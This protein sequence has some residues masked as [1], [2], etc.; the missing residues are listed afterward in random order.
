M[1]ILI[2][3]SSLIA[4]ILAQSPYCKLCLNSS[5]VSNHI[6]CLNP[7]GAWSSACPVTKS[8]V[9]LDAALILKEHNNWRNELANGRI[10]GFKPATNMMKLVSKSLIIE[11]KTSSTAR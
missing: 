8:L 6:I 1:K 5:K 9:P 10:G 7:T 3:F 11:L 2:V 4:S